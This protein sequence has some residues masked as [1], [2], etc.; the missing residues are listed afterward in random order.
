MKRKFCFALM[1]AASL[2]FV[3][4]TNAQ[5]AKGSTILGGSLGFSSSKN[6]AAGNI[7]NKSNYYYVSP[8]VGVAIK[9]NLFVGG[10]LS[11]RGDTRDNTGGSKITNN[12]IG[13][14]A[15]LRQ[16]KNLGTSG[17]YLFGQARLGVDIVNRK[18]D[19]RVGGADPAKS[20]GL[21]VALGFTPGISYAVSKK[22]HLETSL[23][24]LFNV[25]YESTEN[26]AANT[27]NSAFNAG[28]NLGES[29]TWNVGI[30][31]ILAK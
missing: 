29:T 28:V 18:D 16:Y 19:P 5:I 31:V 4:T 27:K 3:N 7:T 12:R 10:D 9:D 26:K 24:N 30:R 2:F 17:F 13:V 22:I 15:F 25:G 1:G 23:A 14:G 8:A 6:E 11:F 20:N 21:G